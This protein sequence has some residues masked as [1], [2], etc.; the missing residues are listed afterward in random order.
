[1]CV[2]HNNIG[3]R[4]DSLGKEILH[5]A[6]ERPFRCERSYFIEHLSCTNDDGSGRDDKQK[7]KKNQL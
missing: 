4:F 3:L 7:E 2:P 1:M 5:D 6:R